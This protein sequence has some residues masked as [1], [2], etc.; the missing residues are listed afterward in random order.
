MTFLV[1]LQV[2]SDM[3]V[4]G[5]SLLCL[6]FCHPLGLWRLCWLSVSG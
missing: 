2:A 4:L 5:H 3:F 1:C 6:W